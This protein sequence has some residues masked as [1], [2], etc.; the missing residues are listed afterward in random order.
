MKVT[1][2]QLGRF[3]CNRVR[4]KLSIRQAWIVCSFITICNQFK[5]FSG[6]SAS[7]ILIP[8]KF[9]TLI[10][11]DRRHRRISSSRGL[12]CF[13]IFNA[14]LQWLY[15][16]N[17]LLSNKKCLFQP[18]L[19]FFYFLII[20]SST[21]SKDT[22]SDNSSLGY[23]WIYPHRKLSYIFSF[24]FSEFGK[25]GIAT[26]NSRELSSR[27]FWKR[28]VFKFGK[29]SQIV[30]FWATLFLVVPLLLQ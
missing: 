3:S 22:A 14:C 27:L 26:R 15:L 23:H 2:G 11:V 12:K 10:N 4:R 9:S 28:H 19:V 21:E 25:P 30:L 6:S 13:D 29:E 16:L 1:R 7:R 8:L 17:L 20:A 18:R 24:N 5:V